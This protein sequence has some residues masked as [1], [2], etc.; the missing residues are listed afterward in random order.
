MSL[1]KPAKTKVEWELDSKL[2]EFIHLLKKL[3]KKDSVSESEYVNGLLSYAIGKILK[4][5]EL[6]K[7]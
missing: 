5:E 2:I 1:P 6:K 3:E 4:V 7:K